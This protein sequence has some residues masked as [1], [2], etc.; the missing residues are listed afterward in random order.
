MIKNKKATIAGRKVL[1]YIIFAFIAAI[2]ALILVYMTTTDASEI[3]NMP[4]GLEQYVLINRFMYSPDCFA[5]NDE[6]I[7]R[8]YPLI[9]WSKFTD[10]NLRYCYNLNS[11]IVKGFEL[12]LTI[13]NEKKEKEE[14]TISTANWQGLLRKK[15]EKRVMV[16]KEGKLYN[17]VLTISIQNEMHLEPLTF[18]TGGSGG[19]GG[20]GGPI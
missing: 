16:L 8:A 14:K 7:D 1:F 2:T 13:E 17:R 3:D 19:G 5:Y 20:A 4:I 18:P 15:I 12:T 11:T 10:G 6:S 9:D